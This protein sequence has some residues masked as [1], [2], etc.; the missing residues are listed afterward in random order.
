MIFL[1]AFI[2]LGFLFFF[3]LIFDVTLINDNCNKYQRALKKSEGIAWDI[4]SRMTSSRNK[5][6]EEKLNTLAENVQSTSDSIN[7]LQQTSANF[8]LDN[9]KH[10]QLNLLNHLDTIE[11]KID[12]FN[13]QQGTWFNCCTGRKKQTDK[14]IFTL[15]VFFLS[16][17]LSFF[18][19]TWD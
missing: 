14:S 3:G 1:F 17:S 6:M 4:R 2:L 5:E 11:R 10:Y 9:T 12:D 18:T 13:H 8:L 15:H 19:L 7:R 16:L